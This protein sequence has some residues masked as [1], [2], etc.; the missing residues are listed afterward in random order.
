M[1]RTILIADDERSITDMLSE[2]LTDEGYAVD[3]V[4]DGGSALVAVRT[5]PPAALILDITMPVMTGDEV[6][7]ALRAQGFTNLPIIIATATLS[8]NRFAQMGANAVV[9]KPYDLIDLLNLVR[10]LAGPP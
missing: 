9:P 6:L 10:H 1:P 4:H 5:R 3:V 8:P 7:Q 2:A